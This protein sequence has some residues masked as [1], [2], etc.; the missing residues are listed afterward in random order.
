MP[1]APLWADVRLCLLLISWRAHVRAVM[2]L[3][4]GWAGIRA[5]MSLP[6]PWRASIRTV[7]SPFPRW[8]GIRV[9]LL[10]S[11]RAHVRASI[12]GPPWRAVIRTIMPLLPGRADIR[13][14]M[15]RS[16]GLGSANNWYVTNY[17]WHLLPSICEGA[18]LQFL[19]LPDCPLSLFRICHNRGFC[20]KRQ[21]VR[22]LL[23]TNREKSTVEHSSCFSK[24]CT[25][26]LRDKRKKAYLHPL[27]LL[28]QCDFESLCCFPHIC[29]RQQAEW[30]EASSFSSLL[31][32]D[33]RPSRLCTSPDMP[34]T[35]WTALR[36]PETLIR[37]V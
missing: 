36:A 23:H 26:A 17:C 6:S 7:M 16:G 11:W 24:L 2:P 5:V 14:V 35:A 10:Q 34:A 29:G 9:C 13:T 12:A 28:L 32:Q 4:S 3:P 25:K 18:C 20:S 31:C 8:A 30:L 15:P 1:S 37:A 22:A 27:L 33:P 19:D 21:Q